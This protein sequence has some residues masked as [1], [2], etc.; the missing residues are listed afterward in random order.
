M[1]IPASKV[2]LYAA[3]GSDYSSALEIADEFGLPDGNIVGS[4]ANA[5]TAAYSGDFML[6]AIGA[7]ANN[8]MYYNPCGFSGYSQGSTPFSRVDVPISNLPGKTYYMN[9]AGETKTDSYDLAYAYVDCA[10]N[11]G[12]CTASLIPIAPEQTCSG[13]NPVNQNASSFGT[14]C[15]GTDACGGNIQNSQSISDIE[16]T[17]VASG[18]DPEAI[19]QTVLNLMSGSGVDIYG[20]DRYMAVAS[21]V[22]QGCYV[23]PNTCYQFGYGC[24]CSSPQDRQGFG[25]LQDTWSSAGRLDHSS[26]ALT[27]LQSNGQSESAWFPEGITPCTV[28]ADPGTAFAEFYWWALAQPYDNCGTIPYWV[29]SPCQDACAAITAYTNQT[30]NSCSYYNPKARCDCSS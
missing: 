2:F 30:G 10:I 25:V 1:T 18:W 16:S 27:S 11:G 23:C 13:R 24:D 9:A 19:A 15:D 22:D 6:I 29:V 3:D 4:F 8:A 20:M 5:W 21:M 26:A 12:D 17:A 28:V 7:P 14:T